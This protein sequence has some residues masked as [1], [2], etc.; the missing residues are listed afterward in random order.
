[1]GLSSGAPSTTNKNSKL[2]SDAAY[3][4]S[5]WVVH[6]W[7]K[8]THDHHHHGHQ[9]RDHHHHGHQDHDQDHHHFAK[10][11]PQPKSRSVIPNRQSLC[12]SLWWDNFRLSHDH[13]VSLKACANLFESPKSHFLDEVSSHRRDWHHPVIAGNKQF[14]SSLMVLSSFTPS[15]KLPLSQS[16]LSFYLLIIPNIKRLWIEDRKHAF[17]FNCMK[18]LQILAAE[19][20]N[21]HFVLSRATKVDSLL[22]VCRVVPACVLSARR[23]WWWWSSR[24]PRRSPSP[25]PSCMRTEFS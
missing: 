9:D 7:R 14:L 13:R 21:S 22:K 25:S 2:E 17:S 5:E 23:W 1:M 20:H 18:S 12:V 8:W 4:M 19:N 10:D 16:R 11:S 24:R 15:P 3:L 6:D